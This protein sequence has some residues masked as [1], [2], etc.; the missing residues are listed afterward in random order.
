MIIIHDTFICKPGNA[1][2]V[3][4]LFKEVMSGRNELVNI[5]TDMTGQYNR[6]IMV[7]K[8]ES[9]AAWENSW[10]EMESNTEEMKK[11]SE[12]MKGYTEMYQSGTREIYKV[13]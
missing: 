1:S 8:F 10:K 7:S 5:M 2:K 11:M 9:L 6:V 12:A 3:A 4:K 13:W